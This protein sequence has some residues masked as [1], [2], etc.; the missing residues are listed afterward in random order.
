MRT[1]GMK[2]ELD[3]E[4]GK[5]FGVCAGLARA[6]GV[7][8]TIFRVGAVL[9]ALFMSFT[10]TICIYG[11]L[12]VFGMVSAKRRSETGRYAQIA[13]SEPSPERIRSHELRMRAIET[14]AASANSRLAREIEDLR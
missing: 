3:R 11:A 2:F 12:A 8:A 13:S 1:R 4:D 10:W 5:L 7:D 9:L 14:Y 6:T